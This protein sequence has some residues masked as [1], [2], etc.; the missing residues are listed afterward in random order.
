MSAQLTEE[1]KATGLYRENWVAVGS[2]NGDTSRCAG[3]DAAGLHLPW[4]ILWALGLRV[5]V[6]V[7]SLIE[8]AQCDQ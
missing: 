6:C 8:F 4:W 7:F 3:V 2:V 5:R 1:L